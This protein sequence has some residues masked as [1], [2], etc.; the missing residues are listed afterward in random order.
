MREWATLARIDIDTISG[1]SSTSGCSLIDFLPFGSF[2]MYYIIYN[3]AALYCIV[4]LNTGKVVISEF[5]CCNLLNI[6]HSVH[7]ISNKQNNL[8]IF[9][10]P[11]CIKHDLDLVVPLV[12]ARVYFYCCYSNLTYQAFNSRLKL[13]PLH[14]YWSWWEEKKNICRKFSSALFNQSSECGGE[15]KMECRLVNVQMWKSRHRLSFHFLWKPEHPDVGDSAEARVIIMYSA[16]QKQ[17]TRDWAVIEFS[18]TR[19]LY[20]ILL[21]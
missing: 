3:T 1:S 4:Q 11:E 12:R 9:L 15:V 20:D 19:V 16:W 2:I 18:F 21:E 10:H 8:F 14:T 17:D 7:I 5:Q 13:D 6:V